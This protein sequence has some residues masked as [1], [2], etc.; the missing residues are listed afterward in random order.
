MFQ[1]HMFHPFTHHVRWN[2]WN[3]CLLFGCQIPASRHGMIRGHQKMHA[4]PC[5]GQEGTSIVQP[6]SSWNS[7]RPQDIAR[8]RWMQMTSWRTRLSW[9]YSMLFDASREHHELGIDNVLF[10]GYCPKLAPELI[11]LYSFL[12]LNWF[13][14]IWTG[15]TKL[16]SRFCCGSMWL[17]LHLERP[18]AW[19]WYQWDPNWRRLEMSGNCCH[20]G[21]YWRTASSVA[22]QYRGYK[23]WMWKGT[24]IPDVDEENSWDVLIWLSLL[25]DVMPLV[26]G[27]ASSA[28]KQAMALEDPQLWSELSDLASLNWSNYF[29]S[30]LEAEAAY[31][32]LYVCQF[33]HLKCRASSQWYQNR[34]LC[35]SWKQW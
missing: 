16:I 29:S 14:S 23:F 13:E 1:S 7:F 11:A 9:Q 21:G 32:C 12:K 27:Q 2:I 24:S 34:P 30:L 5:F 22:A 8:C 4:L 18:R 26:Y 17:L 20:F 35:L 3:S 10:L 33:K 6:G 25:F 19:G 31:V 28:F 15:W